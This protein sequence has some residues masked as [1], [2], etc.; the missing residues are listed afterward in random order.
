MEATGGEP[1]TRAYREQSINSLSLRIA[2]C[3]V[4]GYELP[5]LRPVPYVLYV[6][7]VKCLQTSTLIQFYTM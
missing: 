2:S 1:Y 7:Y 6:N 4:Y 5:L 3:A